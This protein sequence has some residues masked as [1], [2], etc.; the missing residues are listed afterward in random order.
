[1]GSTRKAWEIV[2]K[3]ENNLRVKSWNGQMEGEFVCII[4][5]ILCPQLGYCGPYF[6]ILMGYNS[7][8]LGFLEAKSRYRICNY[9]KQ[10]QS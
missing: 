3:R 7:V 10:D 4:R 2:D 6:N 1:M 9:W 5:F 8:P